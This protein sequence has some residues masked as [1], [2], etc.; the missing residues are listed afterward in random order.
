MVRALLSLALALSACREAP[1]RLDP[2]RPG[3]DGRWVAR[4]LQGLDA[5]GVLALAADRE[6]TVVALWA[7]WCTPC[8]DEMSELEAFARKTPDALVIGL[9]TDADDDLDKVQAVL[10]RVRPSYVQARLRGGEGP[11]LTRLGLEWDGM[12]PKTLVLHRTTGAA[13]PTQPLARLLDPP[14]TAAALD[15]AWQAAARRGR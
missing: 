9:S 8:I 10:D 12:L 14:V 6:L 13:P 11:L 2:P 7:S 1:A 3:P 5:D 4:T 15:A